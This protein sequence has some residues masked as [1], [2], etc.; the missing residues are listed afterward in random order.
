[1]VKLMEKCVQCGFGL[2]I[3]LSMNPF[4]W[5]NGLKCVIFLSFENKMVYC[6][7]S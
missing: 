6:E 2:M 3:A 7:E 5:K 4:E 1:M